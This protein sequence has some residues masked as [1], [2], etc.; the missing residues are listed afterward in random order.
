MGFAGP[1]PSIEPQPDYTSRATLVRTG[2]R[3]RQLA[4]YLKIAGEIRE[5]LRELMKGGEAF[6]G[7]GHI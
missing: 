2:Q 5:P 3:L 7:L 6:L 1:K 4:H